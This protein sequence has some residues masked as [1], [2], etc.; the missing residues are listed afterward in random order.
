MS[1]EGT[2]VGVYLNEPLHFKDW[3][4]RGSEKSGE[5]LDILAEVKETINR[6]SGW[7]TKSSVVLNY[8][9]NSKGSLTACEAIKYDYDFDVQ[10]QHPVCH[11]QNSN[12]IMSHRPES[13][14][15]D[16]D[17]GSLVNR[18]QALRIPTAFVNL[19]GLLEKLT[20]DHLPSDHYTD[21]WEQCQA[22]VDAIPC[23]DRGPIIERITKS[24]SV[25]SRHWYPR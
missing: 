25:R 3:P 12:K 22:V 4:F 2:S 18:H 11:A 5:R 10:P 8:F 7:C 9:V 15:E 17:V 13:F 16:F 24:G 23:H 14:P 19:A 21:F 20:A 1:N 6:E